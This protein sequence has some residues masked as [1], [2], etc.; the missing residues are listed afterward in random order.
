MMTVCSSLLAFGGMPFNLW[1]YGSYWQGEENSFTIPFG[2][3]IT[4]LVFVSGPVIVG[5][6]VRHYHKRAAEIITRVSPV[7]CR[8]GLRAPQAVCQL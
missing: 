5:M 3:I 4:S 6:I 8:S 1:L 2:N 7:C